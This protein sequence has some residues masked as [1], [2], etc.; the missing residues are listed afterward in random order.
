[1]TQQQYKTTPTYRL[2]EEWGP[3]HEKVFR[4]SLSIKGAVVAHGEGKSKKEAEQRAA[5]AAYISMTER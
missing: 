3:P 1:F 4:V 5:K 2:V